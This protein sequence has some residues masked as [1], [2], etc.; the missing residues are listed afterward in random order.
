[1]EKMFD[2][3]YRKILPV[4]EVGDIKSTTG[5]LCTNTIKRNFNKNLPLIH[6]VV[7]RLGSA[8]LACMANPVLLCLKNESRS[9]RLSAPSGSGKT[10]TFSINCDRRREKQLFLQKA[11]SVWDWTHLMCLNTTT[12][13]ATY[14]AEQQLL[15]ITLPYLILCIFVLFVSF[16]IFA[17]IFLIG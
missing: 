14:L 10:L 16:V 17:P 2:M 6:I 8:I 12:T 13:S 7:R 15:L 5:R 1:M 3:C 9:A 11:V 4:Y